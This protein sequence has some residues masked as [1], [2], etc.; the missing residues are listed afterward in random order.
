[1]LKVGHLTKVASVALISASSRSTQRRRLPVMA[2]HVL[3]RWQTC[4]AHR[5]MGFRD[6][7]YRVLHPA[8]YDVLGLKPQNSETNIQSQRP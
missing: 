3:P 5:S 8:S 7:G 1:M 6:W 2:N 4:H